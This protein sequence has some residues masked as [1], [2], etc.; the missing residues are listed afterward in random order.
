[1]TRTTISFRFN[2]P[3]LT[4]SPSQRH[5]FNFMRFLWTF[6]GLFSG[7]HTIFYGQLYLC[8]VPKYILIFSIHFTQF[9]SSSW[10]PR[11][12]TRKT[13]SLDLEIY[14]I[15][16]FI[17]FGFLSKIFWILLSFSSRYTQI[18]TNINE[19]RDKCMCMRYQMRGVMKNLILNSVN[20][21]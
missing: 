6:S 16:S 21:D 7:I 2:Y 8:S 11:K 17:S 5:V 12:I 13:A 4:R 1:M 18:Y 10:F 20:L 19:L 14:F 9:V 3:C 15:K